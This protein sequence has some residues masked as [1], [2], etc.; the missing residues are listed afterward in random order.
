MSVMKRLAIIPGLCK[1]CRRCEMHCAFSH[2]GSFNP[3]LAAIKI[4]RL[5]LETEQYIPNICSHCGICMLGCPEE[6]ALQYDNKTGAI[7]ITEKC[8]GCEECISICPFGLIHIDPLS[9]RAFK[10]DLCDGDPVCVKHC[11]Y[12]ALVWIQETRT[13]DLSFTTRV[14]R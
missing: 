14:V 5:P 3:D 10:C 2:L 7:R 1:G 13:E 6:N 8:T 11:P 4:Q 12:H 9:K